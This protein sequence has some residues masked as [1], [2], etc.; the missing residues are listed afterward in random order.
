MIAISTATDSRCD[1]CSIEGA[2]KITLGAPIPGKGVVQTISVYLCGSCLCD[3]HSLTNPPGR[4]DARNDSRKPASTDKHE[5]CHDCGVPPGS[6]H[7]PGCDVEHCSVCKEQ[8][9]QCDCKDHDPEKSKWTGESPGKVECR[10]L[11]WYSVMT[12]GGWKPCTKDYPG[13]SEDLNRWFY[14]AQTGTDK[15]RNAKLLTCTNEQ[16]EDHN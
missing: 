12:P 8:R 2:V 16:D 9:L 3:L 13:A 11:G 7:V 15:D 1:S 10:E 14:F 5:T 4:P 6:T